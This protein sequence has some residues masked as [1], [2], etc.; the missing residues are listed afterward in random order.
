L[1]DSAGVVGFTGSAADVVFFVHAAASFAAKDAS[2]RTC[3]F[4]KTSAQSSTS[5][6]TRVWKI[7]VAS[8]KIC[9]NQKKTSALQF[10]DV[11][12]L[13]MVGLEQGSRAEYI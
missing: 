5:S 10:G 9:V 2:V 12:F 13:F 3:Y 1:L 6:K 4:S 11:Y 8:R 7:E